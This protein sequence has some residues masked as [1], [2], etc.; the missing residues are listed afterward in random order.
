MRS[1][2][3][4][5]PAH[6]RSRENRRALVLVAGVSNSRFVKDTIVLVAHGTVSDLSEMHEFL[7]EI[8]RGRPVP[9]HLLHEMCERYERVGGSPLLRETR[10]QAVAVQARTGIPT[11]VAMRLSRPRLP[12]VVEDLGKDDRVILVPIAPFS[13]QIYE[14]A[15]RAAL[16]EVSSE[17][18]LACVGPWGSN[19]HLLAAHVSQIEEAMAK[20]AQGRTHV[21]LTAHSLPRIVIERGDPYQAEFEAATYRIAARL[22]VPTTI[23]YQ[24]QGADGGDWL[25]PDLKDVISRLAT[26]E[27]DCL[28]V[29]PIGFLCEHIETLYDLD[30][31][32]KS[33]VESLG[34]QFVRVPTLGTHPGLLLAIESAVAAVGSRASPR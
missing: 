19:E 21:V 5:S 9:E 13:V 26:T 16:S 2:W 18:S 24:S 6:G 1:H 20:E 33:Q 27:V 30:I 4:I 10:A 31:E 8:R 7:L 23:A 28:V 22:S 14:S 12:Q 15:A 32:T 3:K 34:K 17:V 11:R 25:G 29:A